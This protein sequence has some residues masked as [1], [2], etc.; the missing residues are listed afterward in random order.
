I[1]NAR[2]NLHIVFFIS[3]SW[4]RLKYRKAASFFVASRSHSMSFRLALFVRLTNAASLGEDSGQLQLKRVENNGQQ[5]SEVGS[6]RTRFE[7][8]RRA[9]YLFT[10]KHDLILSPTQR[11]KRRGPA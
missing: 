11:K 10:C 7:N 9:W 4:N 8:S 2:T 5:F 1:V 3:T 6:C